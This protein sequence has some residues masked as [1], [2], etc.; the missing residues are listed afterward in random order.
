MCRYEVLTVWWQNLGCPPQHYIQVKTIMEASHV[1]NS[2]FMKES[3][4]RQIQH[5]K[6]LV[7]LLEGRCQLIQTTIVI[8]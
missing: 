6:N 7:P 5:Y 2:Y 3:G 4:L 1:T 8:C